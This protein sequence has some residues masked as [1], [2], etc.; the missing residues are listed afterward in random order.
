MMALSCLVSSASMSAMR[1]LMVVSMSLERR[2]VPFIASST[3]TASWRRDSSRCSS[4]RPIRVS[5]MTWSRKLTSAWLAAAAVV[6][7]PC[8]S[9]AIGSLLATVTGHAHLLA[10]LFQH[11]GV[12]DDLLELLAHF[13]VAV[14]LGQERL[15]LDP[16]LQ[17]LAEG[18]HLFGHLFG[19]EVLDAAEVQLDGHL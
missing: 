1:A 15:E 4:F 18:L 19:L 16:G 17:Q 11:L 12:T 6:W 2:T 14:R 13:V 9:L 8:A 3:S 7:A 5:V 10:E